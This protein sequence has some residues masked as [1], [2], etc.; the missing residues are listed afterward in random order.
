MSVLSGLA[1]LGYEGIKEIDLGKLNPPDMYEDELAVMAEVR[2]Y[3][4]VSYKVR[5]RSKSAYAMLKTRE[6]G[7]PVGLQRVIDYVPLTIDHHFL[8]AFADTIRARLFERLGLGTP[9]AHQRCVA[10]V[11][12]DP[13]VVATRDELLTKKKR[14]E[15]VRQALFTFGMH[16]GA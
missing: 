14:L 4:Q 6:L 1:K 11:A 9:N 3:F 5:S 13:N 15:N 8:Y 10:Y 16:V 7:V 2:A 12:E